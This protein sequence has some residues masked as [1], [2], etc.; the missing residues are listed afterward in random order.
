MRAIGTYRALS[1]VEL[2]QL[3]VGKAHSPIAKHLLDLDWVG[4][5]AL[6]E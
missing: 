3:L 5:K 1:H 6:E 2:T 4:V